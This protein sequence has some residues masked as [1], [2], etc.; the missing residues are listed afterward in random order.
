MLRKRLKFSDLRASLVLAETQ[1]N[2][3]ERLSESQAHETSIISGIARIASRTGTAVDISYLLSYKEV[4]RLEGGNDDSEGIQDFKNSSAGMRIKGKL[5]KL[6][7]IDSRTQHLAQDS[8]PNDDEVYMLR[9]R[10]RYLRISLK[11]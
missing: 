3:T 4:I 10:C 2:R 5:R 8:E 9:R 1:N 6:Q 7:F 11:Y